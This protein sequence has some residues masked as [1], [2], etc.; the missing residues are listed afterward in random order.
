MKKLFL[1]LFLISIFISCEKEISNEINTTK[2]DVDNSMAKKENKID[3]C[4]YEASA[5]T[6]KLINISFNAW[7]THQAHGDVR[8]DDPDHDGFVPQNHCGFGTM[9]DCNDNNASINPGAT[10]ICNGVDDNCNNTVDEGTGDADGDGICD[11]LDNC[12]AI[13]NTDQADGDGDDIG[14]VCDACPNDPNNDADSDGICGDVDNCPSNSNSGQQ[15][16]DCDTVGDACDVCPGGDDRVDNN[17][18]GIADCSQ[19][20][21]YALYSSDWKCGTN[22]IYICHSG[23]TTC[24]SKNQ[25]STHYNHGDNIGPCVSC[26]GQNF[27]IP[28]HTGGIAEMNEHPELEIFPNPANDH[29]QLHYDGDINEIRIISA[30][31]LE[32]RAFETDGDFRG[33]NLEQ[34]PSGFYALM[35]RSGDKWMMM[36]FIK[37]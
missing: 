36:K 24:I 33:I 18:D 30:Q 17:N 25:L 26:G 10:E 11:A 19:L 5:G 3:V 13:A 21:N 2:S 23:L 1:T 4:H 7:P 8:L 14:D 37:L 31:G 32:I 35:I 6:W 28:D 22:K 16:S 12:P 29:I 27:N 15:D 20:L 34:I 9:G